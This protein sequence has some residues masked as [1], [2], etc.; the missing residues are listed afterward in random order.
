MC[1]DAEG[2]GRHAEDLTICVEGLRRD[3]EG[4]GR[5]AEGLTICVEGLRRDGEGVCPL[6]PMR[7]V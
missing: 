1:R 2:L 6:A 4:L 5:H 3:A 7:L